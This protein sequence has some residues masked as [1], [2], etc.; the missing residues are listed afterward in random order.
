MDGQEARH[1]HHPTVELARRAVE[2][3]VRRAASSSTYL[4]R[5]EELAR[6]AV[7]DFVSDDLVVEPIP[8]PDDLPERAGVFVTIRSRGALRGCI[9]TIE[10]VSAS[11]AEEIIRSALL[12]ATDDPRFPPVGSDEL[13][14]LTYSVSVLG[15]VEP[16]PGLSDLD[17]ARFGVIVQSGYRRG[18]LLPG[19]EGLDTPEKQLQAA[20]RK[21]G[22]PSGAPFETLRFETRHF[23]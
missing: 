12:A 19:I 1:P 3:F 20:R 23:E 21:A 7:E 10:P 14:S 22:I 15:Q 6:R 8:L 2:T 16:A 18:L 13:S 11:L 4:L 9:G 5:R 17:P